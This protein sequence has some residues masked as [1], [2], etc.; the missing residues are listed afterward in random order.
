MSDFKI[1]DH[2]LQ[3]EA[4]SLAIEIVDDFRGNLADDESLSDYRDEMTDRAHEYAD[5]HEY[6]IYYHKAIMLCA[7]CDTDQGEQFLEDTGMP[8]K[9]TFA[10]LATIIAYGE[11]RARIESEIDEILESEDSE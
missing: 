9:P 6:A 2:I 1:N 4:E 3:K 11:L 7:H 8:E 5:S 10:G